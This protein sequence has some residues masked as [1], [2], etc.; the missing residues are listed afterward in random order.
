MKHNYCDLFTGKLNNMELVLL[1]KHKDWSEWVE[2]KDQNRYFMVSD[3]FDYFLCL[4]Q[5][6]EACLH[7]LNGG[8]AQILHSPLHDWMTLEGYVQDPKWYSNSDFMSDECKLRIKPKK[9][10]RWMLYSENPVS[11]EVFDN[12]ESFD[13]AS[14][15]ARPWEKWQE[16]EFEIEV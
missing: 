5:H 7:W 13:L 6:K 9:E 2:A 14:K 15:S 1:E 4:P 12:K 11:I 10:K 3:N 16:V 8:E